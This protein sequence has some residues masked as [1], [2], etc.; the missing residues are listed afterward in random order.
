MTSKHHSRSVRPLAQ[1][2]RAL[3]ITQ[4]AIS[5]LW[6]VAAVTAGAALAIVGCAFVL[7]VLWLKA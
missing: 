4:A 6:L 5:E 2:R 7:A 1:G 3:L